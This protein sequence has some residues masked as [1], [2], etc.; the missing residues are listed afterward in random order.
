MLFGL[1]GAGEMG[2]VGCLSL[3][4]GC[5]WCRNGDGYWQQLGM[6]G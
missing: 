5:L 6:G 4:L 3:R 2:D 1:R